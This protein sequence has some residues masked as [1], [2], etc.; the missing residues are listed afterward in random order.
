MKYNI[1]FT[2]IRSLT[3]EDAVKPEPHISGNMDLECARC[4]VVHNKLY[5]PAGESEA[6]YCQR[7]AMQT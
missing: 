1:P 6:V 2:S 7:C 5:K 3:V 4:G